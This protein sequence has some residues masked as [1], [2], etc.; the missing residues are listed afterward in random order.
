[1]G[2]GVTGIPEYGLEFLG[3]RFQLSGQVERVI[4]N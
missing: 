3:G 2:S 4:F 1:M